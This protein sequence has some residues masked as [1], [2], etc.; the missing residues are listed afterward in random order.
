MSSGIDSSYLEQL[1]VA[2]AWPFSDESLAST[3]AWLVTQRLVRFGDLC[4]VC[5]FNEIEGAGELHADVRLFLNRIVQPDKHETGISFQPVSMQKTQ[6][7]LARSL[8][9]RR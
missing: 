4:E 1:F 3:V 2:F 8:L 6:S 7:S 5:D 9:C